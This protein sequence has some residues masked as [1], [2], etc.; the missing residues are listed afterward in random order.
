MML[1]TRESKISGV[2]RSKELPVTQEQLDKW[3]NGELIQV[4]MPHLTDADRE[5]IMSGIV[6][7]EWNSVFDDR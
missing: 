4:A 5:F 1:I 7:E 2:T 3:Y 6:D